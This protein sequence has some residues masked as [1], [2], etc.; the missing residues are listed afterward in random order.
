MNNSTYDGETDFLKDG[1][2]DELYVLTK[3]WISDLEF[4]RDDLQF[5]NYLIEKYFIWINN[6]DNLKLFEEL[7]TNL[8]EVRDMAADLLEK[9]KEHFI[10][11][12]YMVEDSNRKDAGIIKTEHEHLEEEIAQFVKF[13]RARRKEVFT[14]T[15]QVLDAE[16]QENSIES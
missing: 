2:W 1:P 5:L 6:E 8:L 14:I 16:E 3:H 9:M 4:Y 15:K 11:L 7:K 13:F 12:G 10:R